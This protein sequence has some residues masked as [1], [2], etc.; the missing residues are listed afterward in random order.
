MRIA[1][2]AAG[3]TQKQLA[4]LAFCAHT[5]ISAIELAQRVPQRDLIER[6]D[7]E[8]V[9]EERLVRLWDLVER[10]MPPKWAAS[11]IGAEER[12]VAIRSWQP[13]TVHG[14]LQTAGYARAL[15]RGGMAGVPD[16][17]AL[18]ERLERRLRWQ[19]TLTSGK[20]TSFHVIAG[21]ASMHQL[22]GGAEVMREQLL[23]L[24]ELIERRI[25]GVQIP[26]FDVFVGPPAPMTIYDLADGRHVVYL[27]RARDGQTSSDPGTI[28]P[29]ISSFT[30]LRGQAAA[31]GE[32]VRI[33]KAR[34]AEL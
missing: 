18:N 10:E 14:F 4:R 28:G 27:E 30:T 7:A 6:I 26:R 8:L 12:A 19:Q 11:R 31:F 17:Q 29:C 13:T 24:I 32:S 5:M 34:I 23:H 33:I 2:K 9:C 15:F 1:R 20:L 3:L 22:I 16:E 25:V 21:E